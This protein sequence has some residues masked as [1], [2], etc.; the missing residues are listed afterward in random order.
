[1][2]ALLEAIHD[3][4]FQAGH[5]LDLPGAREAVHEP[6]PTVGTAVG[7]AAESV[8]IVHAR[9]YERTDEREAVHVLLDDTAA[10]QGIVALVLALVLVLQILTI[11]LGQ[12]LDHPAAAAVIDLAIET[13]I[14]TEKRITRTET[15]K[16]IV[17]EIGE[18][19]RGLVPAHRLCHTLPRMS[20]KS[21]NSRKSKS[22]KRKPRLTWRLRRTPERKACRSPAL[23]TRRIVV[24]RHLRHDTR[25][26]DKQ[27]TD[28]LLEPGTRDLGADRAATVGTET[29]SANET[30]ETEI[31]TGTG[32]DETAIEIVTENATVTETETENAN[33]ETVI[34]EIVNGTAAERETKTET[35]TETETEIAIAIVTV[36]DATDE[37]AAYRLAERDIAVAAAVGVGVD[38]GGGKELFWKRLLACRNLFNFSRIFHFHD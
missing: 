19:D 1:V 23:T 17:H 37:I 14:E 26:M 22:G 15:K 24:R 10:G 31:G 20:S 29:D 12:T 9:I 16:E 36:T 25:V 18:A 5:G 35:E 30:T 33:K 11:L 13:K 6:N 38:E 7:S 34:E 28:M 2:T 8:E 4:E 21:G 27:L 32:T 3:G